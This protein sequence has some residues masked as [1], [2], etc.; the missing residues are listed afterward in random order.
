VRA[1]R[2]KPSVAVK[3]RAASPHLVDAV[4]GRTFPLTAT[5]ASVV[6]SIIGSG[7]TTSGLL[8][9]LAA[10][11]VPMDRRQVTALLGRLAATGFIE[12][13]GVP[14]PQ[15]VPRQVSPT[16]VMPK[17]RTDLVYKALPRPGH[18][19]VRDLRAG[20]SF[21]FF[22]FE[23]T[24]ARMFDGRRTLAQVAA[25]SERLG[26]K[27]TI[28][29]L[30]NFLRQLDAFGFLVD[31]T[32]DPGRALPSPPPAPSAPQDA[33]LPELRE[34]YNFALNHARAGQL[35]EAEQYLVALLEV[36]GGLA[37][38]KA[39]LA[40]VRS[41]RHASL[42]GVDFQSLHAPAP[43]PP[44]IP[45]VVAAVAPPK[46]KPEPTPATQAPPARTAHVVSESLPP[47][48]TVSTVMKALPELPEPGE[49]ILTFDPRKRHEAPPKSSPSR[50]RK[51]GGG[52]K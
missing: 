23:M 18:V 15:P 34:M 31:S 45:P 14:S 26:L 30:E 49:S 32:R 43:V 11:G 50:A 29:T 38:A 36:D 6:E 4:T 42:A 17:L 47:P 2:L 27:A 24:I 25:A 35:D 3:S 19:E 48:W 12:S 21:T 28:E 20:R 41:R 9:K 52:G 44:A 1:F 46:P 22:E 8:D 5:E 39:L 16:E 10:R 33:W 40:D 13:E 37:E 7:T 51:A